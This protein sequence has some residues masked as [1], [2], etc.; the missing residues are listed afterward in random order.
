MTE[1]RNDLQDQVDAQY[2]TLWALERAGD[3][4]AI[5]EWIGNALDIQLTVRSS[6]LVDD[7]AAYMGRKVSVLVTFGG[8]N[9]YVDLD[10]DESQ[11]LT[12]RGYWGSESV[13]RAIT[14]PLIAQALNDTAD[15]YMGM[16]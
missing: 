14:A 8:P 15:L 7:P 1:I 9:V 12:V 6:V 2:E 4:E 5:H 16:A 11:M 10:S 13:E 3:S